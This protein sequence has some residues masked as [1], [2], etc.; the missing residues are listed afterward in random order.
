MGGEKLQISGVSL[1]PLVSASQWQV[2]SSIGLTKALGST[3][4]DRSDIGSPWHCGITEE[5]CLCSGVI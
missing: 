3:L 5:C 4:V 2:W 1:R